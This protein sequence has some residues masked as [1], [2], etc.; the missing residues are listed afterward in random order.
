MNVC[1]AVDVFVFMIVGS[2]TSEVDLWPRCTIY[3]QSS[4]LDTKHRWPLYAP[5]GPTKAPQ[6]GRHNTEEADTKSFP[7][8]ENEILSTSVDLIA[9]T[10][11]GEDND[12]M[13]NARSG[14][15]ASRKAEVADKRGPSTFAHSWKCDRN[16]KDQSCGLLSPVDAEWP[17]PRSE[18]VCLPRHG[19][20]RSLGTNAYL[21][22]SDG[23]RG[24]RNL[25]LDEKTPEGMPFSNR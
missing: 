11:Q 4:I 15:N 1:V 25:C 13:S 9:R 21:L 6:Q 23:R 10:P 5:G 3:H 14:K 12:A 24:D 20:L 7:G 16:I 2:T 8:E 17:P 19:I 18:S 22:D